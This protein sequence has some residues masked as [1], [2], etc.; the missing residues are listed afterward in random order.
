VNVFRHD[1]IGKDMHPES[2]PGLLQGQQEKF[3]H[4]HL[5]QERKAM[6]ATESEEVRL[7]GMMKPFESVGHGCSQPNEELLPLSYCEAWWSPA[8]APEKRRK[9]GAR[10]C[11]GWT[12][13]RPSVPHPFR[14]FLRKG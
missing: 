7:S 9:D 5:C 11:F 4:L 3:L 14:F 8:L 2:S 12:G 6:V 10:N 1:D 13:K